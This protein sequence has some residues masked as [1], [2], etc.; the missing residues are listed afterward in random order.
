MS[1]EQEI[2]EDVEP[3]IAQTQ[4]S[5]G[6]CIAR[7]RLLTERLRK[8]PFRFL[9]DIAVEVS[10]Q[11]GFGVVELFGA[12][13][14]GHIPEKPTAPSAR[15]EKVDFL[16]RW[17]SVTAA[18]LP[19]HAEALAEVSVVDV[20]CG[21]QPERTNYFLQSYLIGLFDW[22]AA[23][24][25]EP[26]EPSGENWP[27]VDAAPPEE[28]V[29]REEVPEVRAARE[30]AEKAAAQKKA[31]EEEWAR[32]QARTLGS[33]EMSG[34]IMFYSSA[35]TL[36]CDVEPTTKVGPALSIPIFHLSGAT[37][38]T[39]A[40]IK[41]E[42]TSV[43]VK[44]AAQELARFW[45]GPDGLAVRQYLES[46][47]IKPPLLRY[48]GELGAH[49]ICLDPADT[50]A[51]PASVDELLIEVSRFFILKAVNSDTTA[52]KLAH[53]VPTVGRP[54]KRARTASSD[55]GAQLSPSRDVDLIA[56]FA[57]GDLFYFQWEIYHVA[58]WFGECVLHLA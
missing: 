29:R 1:E 18:A 32:I 27:D 9:F 28:S 38:I 17:I 44:A 36:T 31:A 20:V 23:Y 13:D 37:G 16:Q 46:N 42:S 10:R 3:W 19:S 21:V 26:A 49:Y 43:L 11:T 2:S 33:L 34:T 24:V 12:S 55:Q 57:S 15:E 7:P 6:A 39:V 4:A 8:P 30:A 51:S 47:V 50:T 5:L 25:E 40:K 14:A 45:K 53:A 35:P 54:R 58:K 22:L 56:G 52:P 48:L 41:G